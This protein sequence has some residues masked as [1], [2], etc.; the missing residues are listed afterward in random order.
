MVAIVTP[1]PPLLTGGQKSE[2]VPDEEL[3]GVKVSVDWHGVTFHPE[4]R[5]LAEKATWDSFNEDAEEWQR[6]KEAQRQWMEFRGEHGLRDH[7]HIEDHPAVPGKPD[8]QT[9]VELRSRVLLRVS[10]A[11]RCDVQ[12]WVHLESGLHG[13]RDSLLGPGG[14]RILF[15]APNRDDFHVALPG[16]ACAVMGEGGMRSW[17]VFCG[18]NE[19]VA[20]RC[21]VNLDDYNRAVSPLQV[22]ASAQGPEIVTHAKRGLTHRGFA[23]GETE[24]TGVTVYIGQPSSRQ[25]LRVYDKELESKGEMDCVRWELQCREETAQTLMAQMAHGEWGEVVTRRLVAFVDFREDTVGPRG[26]KVDTE[27]RPR[28]GW[29]AQLVGTAV[30]ATAY[31]PKEARTVEQVIEWIDRGVSTSLALAVEFWKGD[32]EPLYSLIEAGKQR[33]KPKHLAMLAGV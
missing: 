14:A 32:M 2:N 3:T 13:Y 33:F 27:D 4:D 5:E 9:E 26:G 15:D 12:D 8:V 11:L 7:A 1:S 25:R 29:F 6:V 17:L 24:T 19:A 30:K 10:I 23:V 28:C 22:E 21:D 20:T 18:E 31:L 16:Q